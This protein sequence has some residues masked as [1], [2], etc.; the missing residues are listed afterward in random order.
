MLNFSSI[1]DA[2]YGCLIVNLDLESS[3]LTT[4]N[5][6]FGRYR[7]LRMPFGLQMSQGVFQANIDQTFE[8]SNGTIGI[9][10]DIVVYEE[11]HARDDGKVYIDGA[12]A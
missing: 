4:F 1:V 9:A 8:G 5:L 3:Y 6:S 2:K 12:K 7:F 10:D 11:A